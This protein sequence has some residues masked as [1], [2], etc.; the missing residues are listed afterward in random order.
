M[1]VI[2]GKTV[3]EICGEIRQPTLDF[4]HIYTRGHPLNH[5]QDSELALICATCH[6]LVHAGEI[7]IEGIYMTSAGPLLISHH[8]GAAYK[9]RPGII[10]GPAGQ[11]EIVEAGDE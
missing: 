11:V 10:F 5:N 8:K 3:C 1:K 6:R 7:I 4:H 2:R 9:I